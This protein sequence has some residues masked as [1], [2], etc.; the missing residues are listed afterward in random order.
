MDI[1]K[2]GL[3][4]DFRFGL[5]SCRRFQANSCRRRFRENA[6]EMFAL[7][8]LIVYRTLCASEQFP[9]IENLDGHGPLHHGLSICLST[10]PSG[11]DRSTHVLIVGCS[12]QVLFC[13]DVWK[14]RLPLPGDFPP[15]Q[16]SGIGNRFGKEN[17]G[18]R[19][20]LLLF[21]TP[22][23][24]LF[25]FSFFLIRNWFLC[26]LVCSHHTLQSQTT[27]AVLSLI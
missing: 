6:D 11:V 17:K 4:D 1:H 24:P 20:R 3:F 13:S 25:G 9:F 18:K 21:L 15:W 23:F 19:V 14:D 16:T 22:C 10:L 12:C 2:K 5:G 26:F 8:R 7:R 27:S